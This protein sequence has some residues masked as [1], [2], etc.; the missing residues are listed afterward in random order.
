MEISNL[1]YA[2]FDTLNFDVK[3]KLRHERHIFL[4]G[5]ARV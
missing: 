3:F 4:G 2:N 1:H 5:E